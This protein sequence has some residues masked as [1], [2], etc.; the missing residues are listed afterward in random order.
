MEPSARRRESI[1]G[2][3]GLVDDE[4]ACAERAE[5]RLPE[6]I[7]G[8]RLLDIQELCRNRLEL[9]IA[10]EAIDQR[11]KC[12]EIGILLVGVKRDAVVTRQRGKFPAD[13][14]QARGIVFGIA[15]ELELEIARA[16]VF[17]CTSATPPPP[18][19]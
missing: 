5:R 14:D 1:I 2:I 11:A 15:V 10:L 19:T 9:T 4:I 17:L 12:C 16:G 13:P 8:H 3:V 6:D 18:S 7:A